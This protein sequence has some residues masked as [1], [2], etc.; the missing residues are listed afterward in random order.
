MAL[1]GPLQPLPKSPLLIRRILRDHVAVTRFPCPCCG[2][3]TLSEGPGAYEYCPVCFWEDD[4]ESLRFP[5]RDVEGPNGVSLMEAQQAYRRHGAMHRSFRRK[6]RRPRRDEPLD[7]GWRPFDPARDWTDPGLERDLWPVNAEALYYWRDT[8]WN[9]DRL[10]VPAPARTPTNDDRLLEHMRQQAPELEQAIAA[11]EQRWG[12]VGA[13]PACG[14]AARAV[15]DAYARNDEAA[16]LRIVNAMLPALDESSDM[17]APSCV[18]IAF[19]EDEGW[20]DPGI[21]HHLDLWPAPVRD[22]IRQQQAYRRRAE[23]E[24]EAQGTSWLELHRTGAGQPVDLIA[25]QLR[26]FEVHGGERPESALGREMTARVI[27]DPRWLYRHPVDSLRLAWR[28]RRT[29]RPWRTLHWLSRP[30]YAG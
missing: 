23:A 26:S 16:G 24:Q 30:R 1:R 19:L 28:F 9:G 5:M 14:E 20:H 12:V 6:V 22:E 15:Q 7:E 13:F 2:H 18:V 3:L 29:R 8:Y 10:K 21:Q 11:L 27:S 4:G 25:D 17:Y